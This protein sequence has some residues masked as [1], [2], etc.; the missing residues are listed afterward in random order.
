MNEIKDV[1]IENLI[2]EVRGKQVM[3]DSDLARLYGC[4]N[5]TKEINQAVKRNQ[6]K[7]PSDFCF[8]ITK[9]EYE[10][11]KS[12]FVTSTNIIPKHGGI[13]KLPFVFTEDGV[14]MI[15]TIKIINKIV[16]IL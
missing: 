7:F 10:N 5:G 15:A 6:N 8:Q 13:R 12:Q 14:A 4:K 3:L 16:N 2:Y 9:Y 1:K 11:L